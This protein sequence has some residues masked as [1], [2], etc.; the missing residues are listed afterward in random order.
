MSL[1]FKQYARKVG[2]VEA[3]KVDDLTQVVGTDGNLTAHPGDYVVRDGVKQ[4]ATYEPNKKGE[5]VAGK[6]DVDVYAVIDGSTF[7]AEH[8]MPE[9]AASE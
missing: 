5:M 7:E 4:I 3:A 1:D 2:S 8:E 6:K 9:A